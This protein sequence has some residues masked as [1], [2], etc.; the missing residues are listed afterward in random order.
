VDDVFVPENRSVT[1]QDLGEGTTPGTQ[2]H[3]S[4]L[5]RAPAWSIFR[6]T[7]SSSAN[8]IARGALD[9]YLD[10]MKG[11]TTNYGHE[12]LH[13]KP[14]IQLRALNMVWTGS[15]AKIIDMIAT[16]HDE[17][18]GFEIAS[19]MSNAWTLPADKAEASMRLFSE[20]VMPHFKGESVQPSRS[21]VPPGGHEMGN[22]G[23]FRFLFGN[24][25]TACP[26]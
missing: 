11:R 6:F 12:P 17:V 14:T 7:I 23:S 10:D 13:E 3:D 24:P 8:G 21:I 4:P 20:E 26:G 19:L 2:V 25:A 9:S 5:Y 1:L 16:L 22:S 18:G 15:P